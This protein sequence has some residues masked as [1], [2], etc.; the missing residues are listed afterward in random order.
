[1]FK[2]SLSFL[3]TN[4][5]SQALRSHQSATAPHGS[6]MSHLKK[7]LGET[8]QCKGFLFQC[9]FFYS[10]QANVSNH[11]KIAQLLRLPIGK[12][13]CHVGTTWRAQIILLF[14]R[15]FDHML[16]GMEISNCQTTH[17][18][19]QCSRVCHWVLYIRS[20]KW[21][22]WASTECCFR[23]GSELRGDRWASM[24]KW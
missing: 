13:L 20:R 22:E 14:W 9:S 7:F 17:W 15:V 10:G 3:H 24:S 12:A 6:L 4:S 8:T 19:K 1:M 11:Q 16:E 18:E 21:M 23:R 2:L 5:F